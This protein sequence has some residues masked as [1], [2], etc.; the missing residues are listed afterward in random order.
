MKENAVSLLVRDTFFDNRDTRMFWEFLNNYFNWIKNVIRIDIQL[1]KFDSEIC[2]FRDSNIWCFAFISNQLLISFGA[3]RKLDL[4]FFE[5]S[6]FALPQHF[7]SLLSFLI[8]IFSKCGLLDLRR[9]HIHIFHCFLWTNII[10]VVFFLIR[11]THLS[12]IF[13]LYIKRFKV[14]RVV[15]LKLVFTD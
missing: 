4:T 13:V 7:L 11:I 8:S 12:R 2:I 9:I 3:I 15:N 6:G 1:T 14:A 10:C 5:K